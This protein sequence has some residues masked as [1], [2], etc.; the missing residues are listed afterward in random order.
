MFDF[1]SEGVS[2]YF[3]EFIP[4]KE[5]INLRTNEARRSL[6]SQKP[7]RVTDWK[8]TRGSV[9]EGDV[10]GTT[11]IGINYPLSCGIWTILRVSCRVGVFAD[12]T[13]LGEGAWY[14]R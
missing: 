3:G 12:S 2:V 9:H 5:L 6:L 4:W 13:K 7:A 10:L 14:V 1:V 11:A 8:R